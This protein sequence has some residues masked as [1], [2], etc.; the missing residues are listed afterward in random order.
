[1]KALIA[2]LLFAF[3]IFSTSVEAQP[4][5]TNYNN[6][7]WYKTVES[8]S[9]RTTFLSSDNS[10]SSI[11]LDYDINDNGY[12]EGNKVWSHDNRSQAPIGDYI[13]VLLTVGVL[14]G[15]LKFSKYQTSE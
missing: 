13:P 1:M 2:A 6:R 5:K 14:L 10:Y 4:S 11:F 12:F 8:N 3:M 9:Q 15:V 7:S